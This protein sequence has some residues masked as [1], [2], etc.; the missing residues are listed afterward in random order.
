ME[1]SIGRVAVKQGYRLI[2]RQRRRAASEFQLTEKALAQ[3]EAF[4]AGIRESI[5]HIEEEEP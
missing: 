4:V 3:P 1:K 2:M 5:E